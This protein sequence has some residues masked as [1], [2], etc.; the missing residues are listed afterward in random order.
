MVAREAATL[1]YFG[2]EKEYKQAKLKAAR[3]FGVKFLPTN[4]EVAMELDKTAEENEGL[5][6]RER[7]IEKRSEALE[8][9]RILRAYKP[10]LIGSVWRGTAHRESD[11]DVVV[12]HDDP[13]DV[14][15]VLERNSI[16][17]THTECV[18]VTKRGLRISSFHIYARLPSKD[19]AEIKVRSSEEIGRKEKCEIYGDEITGLRISELEK[20]LK[21]NPEKRF[22]P[23]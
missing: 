12:Y 15:E 5:T 6:R 7:L 14:L 17:I 9:M 3:T 13:E 20:L 18:S 23:A 1:L 11:V 4:L 22:L 8:L 10:L 21:E 16:R 2:L 19:K